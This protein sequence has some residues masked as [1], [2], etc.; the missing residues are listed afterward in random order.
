M[1]EQQL[2]ELITQQK[3]VNAIFDAASSVIKGED[4]KSLDG[5]SKDLL[6]TQANA[7]QA[8]LGIISVRIGLNIASIQKGRKTSTPEATESV[9][10]I[11]NAG[12]RP[13]SIPESPQS[14]VN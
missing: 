11:P 9:E 13:E 5:L 1:T 7:A 14:D 8:L 4:F 10:P 6:I 2:A 3:Q 12:I